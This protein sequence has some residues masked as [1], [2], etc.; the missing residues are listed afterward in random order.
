MCSLLINDSFQQELKKSSAWK[1]QVE[2][3]KKQI[4]ELHS[5]YNEETKRADK[6]EFDYKKANEQLKAVTR[7]KEVSSTIKIM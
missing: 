6:C 2:V 7:E 1:T 4:A 3:Y 5:K